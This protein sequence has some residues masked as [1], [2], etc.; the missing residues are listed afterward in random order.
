MYLIICAGIHD[1]QLTQSFL[2]SLLQAQANRMQPDQ[3][4]P[5]IF[6]VEKYPP[7]S[8]LH[9]LWF[10]HQQLSSEYPDRLLQIPLVFV[11][12]SAG[13]V[14]AIGAAWGWQ[15]MGGIVKAFIAVDGWGVPLWG[16]FPIHRI[17]HD[18]FTHW[19]SAL[20]GAGWDSFYADPP[21]AHLELW[22]SPQATNGWSIPANASPSKSY[23]TAADFLVNLLQQYENDQR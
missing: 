3:P 21:V 22:R 6:P 9:I 10:V 14:G 1:P 16:N 19:S 18:Y 8:G 7:Y 23:T 20:L 2:A 15:L 5:L 11:G 12:F 4:Q 13:V 17:S